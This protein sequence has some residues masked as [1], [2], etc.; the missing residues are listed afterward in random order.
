M[1]IDTVLFRQPAGL[2]D[3]LF[4]QKMIKTFAV[5]KKVIYPLL[6]QLMY[7]KDILIHPGVEYVDS[8]AEFPYK[9][10]YN[11][12]TKTIKEYDNVIFIPAESADKSFSGCVMRAK[13]KACNMDWSDWRDYLSFKRNIDNENLL[14]YHKLGLSDDT[15][16]NFINRQFGTPPGTYIKQNVRSYNNLLNIEMR[17][18]DGFSPLDWLKV[19]ECA[20]AIYT[21]DTA[22]LFLMEKITLKA[23][24]L[25]M[26]GRWGHYNDIDGLFTLPWRYN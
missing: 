15:K 8:T 17:Y 4:L 20:S 5:D 2:G 21:V 9:N 7:L 6:P 24:E 26:W 22:L 25:Q 13:Y 12:G 19:I 1:S 3:I 11:S 23:S 14:F 16:Y 18:I 10:I